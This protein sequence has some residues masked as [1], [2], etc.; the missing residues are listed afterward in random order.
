MCDK[1]IGGRR[2]LWKKSAPHADGPG[3]APRIPIR[4]SSSRP[5]CHLISS[6]VLSNT[7]RTKNGTRAMRSKRR[8]IRG[9]PR[10][11]IEAPLLFYHAGYFLAI[12]VIS[13]M[14]KSVL[15]VPALF[16]HQLIAYWG[17]P[18]NFATPMAH[19]VINAVNA[20]CGVW[21][22]FVESEQAFNPSYH[23]AL[24]I[25]CIDV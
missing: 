10:G 5:A 1:I 20:V 16:G 22:W 25:V 8:S 11:A 15:F 24:R 12:L 7:A 4:R 14:T 17:M 6:L 21:R 2:F 23:A 19:M 9:C 18:H 13:G 3:S